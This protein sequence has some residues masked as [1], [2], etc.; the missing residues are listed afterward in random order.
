[1]QLTVVFLVASAALAAPY[2][3]GTF[4][5]CTES[6]CIDGCERGAFPLDTC[7]ESATPGVYAVATCSEDGTT[8]TESHSYSPTCDGPSRGNTTIATHTCNVYQGVRYITYNCSVN[9]ST[10]VIVA[11][12]TPTR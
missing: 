4:H 6:A 9:T 1:M 8:I 11:D 7:V 12:Y 3:I 2:N 10:S 5:V